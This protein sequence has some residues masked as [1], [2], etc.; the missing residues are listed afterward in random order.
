M[1]HVRLVVHLA[2]GI[3]LL[4][5]VCGFKPVVEG[6]GVS[7]YS[8]LHALVLDHNLD[9]AAVYE[10]AHRVG[11]TTWPELVDARTPT[12]RRADFYPIG[13][14]LLGLPFYLFALA[15]HP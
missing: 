15:L 5:L 10:E 12:G 2:A 8:Y 3:A 1:S 6:D 14:A 13:S 9:M 4:F 7:Y 11:V